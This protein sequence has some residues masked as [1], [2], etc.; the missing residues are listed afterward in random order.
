MLF[1]PV[2]LLDED[3]DERL[4]AGLGRDFAGPAYAPATTTLTGEQWHH[5]W[6]RQQSLE[7]TQLLARTLTP[8]ERAA[9]LERR[10][11]YRLLE[12]ALRLQRRLE[13]PQ[14]NHARARQA[15]LK[16]ADELA[17]LPPVQA[18]T[19]RAVRSVYGFAP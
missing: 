11:Q 16:R 18:A 1:G 13:P 8:E 5:R 19:L 15:Y 12:L 9:W 17:E 6:A 10:R 2:E 7:H 3:A 14:N 4:L